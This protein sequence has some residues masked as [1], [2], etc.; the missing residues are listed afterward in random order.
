MK[1]KDCM[2]PKVNWIQPD[3]TIQDAA[4]LMAESDAGALPVGEEDRL[5]GMITDR[6]ITVRAIAAGMSPETLVREIMTRELKYCFDDE[7]V[8]HVAK[9]MGEIQVR[10]LPVMNRERRLVGIVTLGDLAGAANPKVVG[11]ALGDVSRRGGQH[12]QSEARH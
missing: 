5:I 1:V 9:N 4:K 3:M 7:S 6:D 2:T 12:T 11:E 8:E 10:R